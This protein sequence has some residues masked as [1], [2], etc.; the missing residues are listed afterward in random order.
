MVSTKIAKVRNFQKKSAN[1]RFHANI[2]ALAG[3]IVE[4][5][6]GEYSKEKQ[7]LLIFSRNHDFVLEENPIYQKRSSVNPHA[8][9]NN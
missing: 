1:P 4:N 2:R 8:S 9:A 3:L 6:R 7:E 5:C